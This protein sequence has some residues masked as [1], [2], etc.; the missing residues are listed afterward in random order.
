M[1]LGTFH[2][3]VLSK[4]WF[5]VLNSHVKVDQAMGIVLVLQPDNTFY[6]I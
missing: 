3:C 4:V 5:G 1:S 2:G 6:K